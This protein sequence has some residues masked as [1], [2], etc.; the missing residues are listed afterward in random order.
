M[1]CKRYLNVLLLIVVFL[2]TGCK[3]DIINLKEQINIYIQRIKTNEKECQNVLNSLLNIIKIEEMFLYLSIDD[4]KINTYDIIS[5][6]N[7]LNKY[8]RAKISKLP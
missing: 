7:F 2:F 6:K 5:L 8:N 3:K 1:E 4:E